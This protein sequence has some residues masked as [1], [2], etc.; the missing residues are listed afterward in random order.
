[1]LTEVQTGQTMQLLCTN[2]HVKFRV[3]LVQATSPCD[4]PQFP[5]LLTLIACGDAAYYESV[6]TD[7]VHSIG[8]VCRP[9]GQNA[10][11]IL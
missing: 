11:I 7:A 6:Q 9:A 3:R 10:K 5:F 4:V 1:M 2:L 8:S